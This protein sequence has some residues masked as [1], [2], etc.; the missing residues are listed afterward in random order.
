MNEELRSYIENRRRHVQAARG[1]AVHQNG[2]WAADGALHEL[3]RMVSWLDLRRE[4]ELLDVQLRD[5]TDGPFV[6]EPT[7]DNV[8]DG[9]E[10]APRVAEEVE[11]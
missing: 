3:D 6:A 1:S 7:A 5:A 4:R 10:R 9:V 2:E 11:R 8:I